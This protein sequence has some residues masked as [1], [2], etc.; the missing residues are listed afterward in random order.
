MPYFLVDGKSVYDKLREPK[1]HLLNIFD[2]SNAQNDEQSLKRK[3]E[4]QYGDLVDFNT[5]SLDHKVAEVFGTNKPFSVLLRPDN[6]IG[7]LSKDSALSGVGVYL[8]Q[9]IGHALE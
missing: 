6:Y 4:S 5:I 9:F 8:N 7:A 3:L 2:G 1:F